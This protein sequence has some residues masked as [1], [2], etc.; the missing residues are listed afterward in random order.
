MGAVPEIACP[1]VTGVIKEGWSGRGGGVNHFG[2]MVQ[3]YEY[4]CTTRVVGLIL[5]VR[6]WGFY[7]QG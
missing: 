5:L 7:G 4:I 3:P 6:L 1:P 2:P